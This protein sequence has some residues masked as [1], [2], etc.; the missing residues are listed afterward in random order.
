MKDE[1]TGRLDRILKN[2]SSGKEA[3]KFASDHG[4]DYGHFFEYFN[5]YIA[6]T[7]G[8][9]SDIIKRSGISRN[10]VYNI[11]DGITK[12]PGRDK[13]IAICIASG[14]DLDQLNR[15]LKIAGHNSLYPKNPRDIYIAA[16]VNRGM[17]DVTK[18]NLELEA[19]GQ[20]IIDV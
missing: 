15:G 5:E 12:K 3:E 18:I 13:I 16:C 19:Q 9:V 10:Y 14:M 20:N 4:R 7:G 1:T 2:V 17:T 11:I 8:V 6:A